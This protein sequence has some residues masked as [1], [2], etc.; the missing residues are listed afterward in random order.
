MAL[1]PLLQPLHFYAE[2][3]IELKGDLSLP[4][5]CRGL[6]VFSHGSG[7][8]RNSPRN[9]QVAAELLRHHIGT[10]LFDLLTE[11]EDTTY[12]NRFNIPLLTGRLVAA[13]H[14]L[15]GRPDTQSLP[16]AFFGASTGAASALM[17]AAQLPDIVAVVSR[18]GRPDLA[19]PALAKVKAAVLLIVGSLDTQVLELNE[20]AFT[21]LQ[22]PKELLVIPGATH[23]FEEQGKL[24]AMAVAAR[25]WFQAHFEATAGTV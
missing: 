18:G 6:V 25:K 23:L 15:R 16:M 1:P 8:S 2:P 3:G 4:E 9:Q 20:A 22:S 7:S 17:A 5:K 11:E 12:A 10:L 14:W 19:A 24:E 21:V 13:V